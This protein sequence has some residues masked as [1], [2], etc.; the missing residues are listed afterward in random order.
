MGLRRL[1]GLDPLPVPPAEDWDAEEEATARDEARRLVHWVLEGEH[2]ADKLF[3][4]GAA[5][6]LFLLG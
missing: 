1:F 3:A 2:G 4:F 6:R 5:C